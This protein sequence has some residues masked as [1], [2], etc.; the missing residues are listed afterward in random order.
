MI[1]NKSSYGA[2]TIKNI[3]GLPRPADIVDESEDTWDNFEF[4]NMIVEY[5]DNQIVES[6][7]R[8]QNY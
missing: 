8:E 7:I 3:K 5:E 2:Y 4:D 1:K 6:I